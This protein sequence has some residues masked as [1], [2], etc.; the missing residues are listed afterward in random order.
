MTVNQMPSD[1]ATSIPGNRRIDSP[2]RRFAADYMES[3]AGTVGL[4]GL[5]LVILLALLAPVISPQNPYDLGEINILDSVLPPGSTGFEGDYYVLGSD[6]QGRDM[7]SAIFHG[8]RISLA[9]GVSSA[10][11]ALIIGTTIGLVAAYIGGRVEAFVMRVVDIQISFPSLLIALIF[12]AVLGSGTWKIVLALIVIQWAYYARTV[13]GVAVAEREKEY[14]EAAH[15]LTLNSRS[16]IFRHLLPNCLPP[17]IVVV[18][19]STASAIS[20]EATLS[21]LGIGLPV[22]EPSLGMLIANG[23]RWL[24]SGNYWISMFPGIALLI[25]V[26]CINLIGDRLRDIL[27]PKLRE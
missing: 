1:G 26:A 27:N 13:R 9:V 2:W 8:L 17:L 19:V 7:L 20:T 11:I 21:F 6:G 18:T 22:T 24:L 3:T 25:T 16:I 10:F 23:F 4:A 5:V 15:S 12:V 14:I